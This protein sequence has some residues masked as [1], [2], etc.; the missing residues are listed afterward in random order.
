MGEAARMYFHKDVG[1]LTLAESALLAGMI[2]SPNPY[3][4]YRHAKRATERRNVVLRAMQESGFVDAATA[5][6]TIAQ[7][8][9]VES[10]SLD[11]SDAPYFVDLVKQQLSERYDAKDLATQNLAVYTLS[12]IHIS[13]PTR[14]LS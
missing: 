4:P 1:N 13:E 3:S 11:S 10:A 8:V 14:L 2:Q 9:R 12:L 7:P 5:E 6:A